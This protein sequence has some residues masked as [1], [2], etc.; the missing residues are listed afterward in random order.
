VPWRKH[1]YVITIVSLTKPTPRSLSQFP[2]IYLKA[3]A[4]WRFL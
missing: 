2:S 4:T 3:L 1:V